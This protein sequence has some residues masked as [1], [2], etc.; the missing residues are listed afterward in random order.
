MKKVVLFTAVLMLAG[1][2]SLSAEAPKFEPSV[3]LTGA[4]SFT[5]GVELGHDSTDAGIV[6]AIDTDIALTLVPTGTDE[7]GGKEGEQV[8]GWIKLKDF[9]VILE[10]DGDG[11]GRDDAVNA[12]ASGIEAKLFVG[13]IFIDVLGDADAIDEAGTILSSTTVA[14]TT[15]IAPDFTNDP[16]DQVGL[17][18]TGTTGIHIGLVD[19]S[20]ISLVVGIQSRSSYVDQANDGNWNFFGKLGF[21]AVPDLTAEVLFNYSTIED[22]SP[23][24]GGKVGYA[25]ALAEGYKLGLT[26]AVDVLLADTTALQVTGELTLSVP[27]ASIEDAE[28]FG[29]TD[30]DYKA[31]LDAIFS[32][33]SAA[34]STMDLG[35]YF[36]DADLL[37]IVNVLAAFEI[38]DLGGDAA[39]TGIG[40]DVGATFDGGI[41]PHAAFWTTSDSSGTLTQF[42]KVYVDLTMITNTTFTLAFTSG[43]MANDTDKTG[44]IEF[45]TK[46]A[47]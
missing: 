39:T 10:D 1:A 27:G 14:A 11:D 23:G 19:T 36:Y 9:K 6:N 21:T 25:I 24:V 17:D 2:I 42:L 44:T 28:Y 15:S 12:A 26:G 41:A 40:I 47:Y 35:V 13:P 37:P 46:I 31:G 8:Y 34:D 16:L 29:S 45:T 7:K 38:S 4:A 20:V 5:F 18:E 3:A 33:L 32:L 22:S 30:I 43:D